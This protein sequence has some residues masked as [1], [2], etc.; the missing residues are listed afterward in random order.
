MSIN[1]NRTDWIYLHPNEY[2]MSQEEI[3]TLFAPNKLGFVYKIWHAPTG[4]FYIGQKVFQFQKTKQPLKG[5]TNKRR[6]HVPSDWKDYW[7]SSKALQ[8]FIAEHGTEGFMREILH[9]C[10]TQ[11]ELTY[12]ELKEQM[13]NDVL[14]NPL[15]WNGIINVR[16]GRRSYS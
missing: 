9:F 4:R 15:S 16:L 1:P 8:Q 3:E 14:H 13:A 2:V 6:S 7:G 10:D 12:L 11:W 5:R